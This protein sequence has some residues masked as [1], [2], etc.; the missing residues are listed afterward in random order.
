MRQAGVIEV[1]GKGGNSVKG[2]G[3]EVRPGHCVREH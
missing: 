3:D 1:D 2:E